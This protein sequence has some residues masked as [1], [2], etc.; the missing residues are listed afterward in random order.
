MD[1]KKLTKMMEA[2]R[3]QTTQWVAQEILHRFG[4]SLSSIR[5]R[6]ETL[7]GQ[8]DHHHRDNAQGILDQIES[9][10]K[11]ISGLKY[12][13]HPTAQGNPK[14]V[15]LHQMIEDIILFLQ[16]RLSSAKIN[17][18]N[19]VPEDLEIDASEVPLKQV[20]MPLFFNAIEALEISK[21]EEKALI[22]HF[23]KT[24]KNQIL[25]I[26]DTGEGIRPELQAS[27]FKPFFTTKPGHV[28]L[29]L[30]I[31][32]KICQEQGWELQI[33]SDQEHGTRV[34]LLSPG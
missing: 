17:V 29:S 14:R 28:G 24:G 3:I 15:R 5:G 11:L 13:V 18:M 1:V 4:G 7:K 19:L 27:L 30:I 22:V 23:Q 31:C 25:S 21:K 32:Q 26:E 20:V 34:E 8:L 2:D 9:L 6:A 12:L 16:F 10:E 33:K